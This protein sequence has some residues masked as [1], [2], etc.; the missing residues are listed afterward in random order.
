MP[1][2]TETCDKCRTPTITGHSWTL[3]AGRRLWRLCCICTDQLIHDLDH[4][5]VDQ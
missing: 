1:D 2:T 4:T 5:T 3:D